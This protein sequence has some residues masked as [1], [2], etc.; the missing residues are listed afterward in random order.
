[1]TTALSYAFLAAAACAA[2]VAFTL[3]T[4]NRR[5][6]ER[7]TEQ[8][9]EHKEDLRSWENEGGTVAVAATDRSSP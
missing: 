2:L 8:W 3:L 1:M 9:R 5:R 7:Q 6:R 4:T